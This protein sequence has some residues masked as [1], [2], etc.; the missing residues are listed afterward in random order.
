M[1]DDDGRMGVMVHPTGTVAFL[2]TDVEGSTAMWDAEPAATAEA[3]ARLDQILDDS[4]STGHRAAEQGAGDSAV[5]AFERVSEAAAAAITTA[6]AIANEAWRTSEPIR[7]R[8]A[9]HVGEVV[10]DEGGRYRGP[11]MNR[12]GRLLA[13]AHGGQV[14]AS[15]AFVGLLLERDERIED[16][17][18]ELD[19]LSWIDLGEHHLRGIESPMRVWQ[20]RHRDIEEEHPPLRTPEGRGLHLPGTTSALIGREREVETLREM[21]SGDRIVTIVGSGGSG[22]TRLAV[23]AARHA[24][25]DFDDVAWVDLAKAGVTDMIEPLVV[26]EMAL[27]HGASDRRRRLVGHLRPRRALLVFDNCEHVL[28]AVAE[29]TEV[30]VEHCP[31][32]HVLATSREPLELAGETL[33]RLGPLDVPERGSD[34]SRSAAGVLFADR[35]KRARSGRTLVDSEL[36][37]AVEICRRLDGIPLALELAAARARSMPLAAIASRLEERFALLVGGRRTALARQRTLEASVAW[38]YDLLEEPEQAALRHLAVCSGP[39]DLVAAEALVAVDGVAPDGL[40][41]ALVDKS[42]LLDESG[43]G[44]AR[45]RMLETVRFYARDRSVQASDAAASRDR[46]LSW[47]LA[48][49]DGADARFESADAAATVARVD[50]ILDEVRAAMEWA[51]STGRGEDVLRIGSSLGWY[52]VWRGLGGEAIEWFDRAETA[53]G[54]PTADVDLAAVVGFARHNAVAHHQP[55]HDQIERAASAGI[56]AARAAG[57]VGVEA[58][59][60][61]LLEVHRSFHDPVGRRAALEAAAELCRDNAG[62]YWATMADVLVAQSHMF[63][64]QLLEPEAL[65]ASAERTALSIGNHQLICE[66]MARRCAIAEGLGDYDAAVAAMEKLDEVVAGVSTRDV[67]A[68]ALRSVSLV[69]LRRGDVGGVID[70]LQLALDQYLQDEDLQFVPLITD[71]LANALVAAGRPDEAVRLLEPVW[72]HPE[73]RTSR[74]YAPIVSAPYAEALW[75]AGD[76]ST[77]RHVVVLAREDA[78]A[79]ETAVVDAWIGLLDG[80][81]DLDESKTASAEA[82]IHGALRALHV[83]GRRQHVCDALEAMARLELDFGRANAAAVLLGAASRERDAQGVVLRPA[84]QASYLESIEAT[85]A[86]LGEDRYADHWGR[87]RELDLDEA[88]ELA[89]RGRGERTRP[90]AGWDALTGTEMRVA[91]LAAEGLTNRN[92]ADRLIVGQETVKS[93]M[94]SILRKLSLTNR[95]QL[96]RAMSERSQLPGP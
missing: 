50:A 52:W 11:T 57:N 35:V 87:G 23:D 69:E 17:P 94:K 58:R 8:M 54:S 59:C 92:I 13:A 70:R 44:A 40:V 7:V 96:A 76:R 84:H 85:R 38:S 62:P 53:A 73:I 30:L 39:F 22:K 86:E 66:T 47:I 78:R 49:V 29:L 81:F 18:D 48:E 80:I 71:P 79:I 16:E 27:H 10:V 31:A 33:L 51:L 90:T 95:T 74:V 77:A 37:E 72:N 45:Y 88:V 25:E 34:L 42:L 67:R 64:Q 89:E 28:S 55:A 93:H 68:I 63:Q 3:I 14:V 41:A 2:F 21:V 46:H 26:A 83:A 19:E 4:A 9:L 65:V 36:T 6:V 1:V 32:L 61:L 5:I 75:A 20:A 12:C 43:A 56:A 15:G 82:K 60:R 24:L 91:T